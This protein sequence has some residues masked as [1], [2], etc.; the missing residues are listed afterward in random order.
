MHAACTTRLGI[1]LLTAGVLWG[2]AAPAQAEIQ[3]PGGATVHK[4]DFERHIMGLFGRLGCNAGSCHGS[5]QGKGGL[6]LSLFGYEPAKDYC[7]LTRESHGRRINPVDPDNSLLLL[8][9]TGQIDHGGGRRIGKDSWAYQLCREW[10][11]SGAQWN[12]GSGDVACIRVDPPEYAFKKPAELRQ[13]KVMAKFTDGSEAKHHA[14][15][16]LPHQR[17]R[18]RQGRR[19]SARSRRCGPATRPSSFPI[20]ATCCRCASWSPI[21]TPA[22]FQYPKVRRGQLHRPRSVRQA[23]AAEHRSQRPVRRCRVPAPRLSS[24]PSARLP[25]PKEVREVLGRHATRQARKARSTNCWPIRC[26]PRCGPPSSATS[27][28]TTPTCW[29]TRSSS[30]PSEARCGTTGSASASPRTCR[31]T[32]SSTACCARPAGTASRR[33]NGSKKSRR[34]RKPTRQGLRDQVRRQGHAR[35]VLAPAAARDHRAVGREDGRGFP[36][37]PRSNAPSATSTR[38]TAGR[39]PTTAPTPTSSRAVNF[40]VSPETKKAF[41][42]EN[43][44][45][46]SAER[47]AKNNQKF[48][49]DPRSLRRLRGRRAR[50][51][52]GTAEPRHGKPLPAKALGGPEIEVKAARTRA[53]RFSN[54]WTRRTIRTSP[55][56]SSTASGAIISASA[57]SIRWTISRWPIRRR[58][59]SCSTRWPRTSSSNKFDIRQLERTILLSRTYQLV[60]ATNEDQQARP[61]QLLAQLRPADDGRG[62]G[63]HAERRAWASTENFGTDGTAGLP[64][65]RGRRQPGAERRG[66]CAFRIFGRPAR[67]SACECDRTLE[68]ALTQTLFR[69]TDPAIAVRKTHRQDGRL[70]TMLQS[71]MTMSEMLE[72]M[73]L[74]TLTRKPDRQGAGRHSRPTARR[75]R[76][77]GPR[78]A[79]PSGR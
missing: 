29:K 16:R 73:F 4:V 50:C 41:D 21:E 52:G 33:R 57:S 34:P 11:V 2:L 36:R 27:P 53:R 40:G 6:R 44:D 79:T 49:A 14:V 38:S 72:E 7:A 13:L 71:K 8:K 3:L 32:R 51:N 66:R 25:T 61:R 60:H 45:S 24:T 77:A 47:A 37:R 74:A 75:T 48:N 65:H 43:A 31:T 76:I 18:R 70:Q 9:A 68:P 28:A 67:A 23:E 55:A 35:P 64:G 46:K 30:G 10:I 15:L 58:T 78:S 69:M 5:F 63:G 62:R 54:G 22:G 26:T 20:A 1:T 56:A 12:K 17:R 19:R 39:R 42:V 59:R